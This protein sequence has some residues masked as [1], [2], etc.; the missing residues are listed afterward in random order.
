[1]LS[2]PLDVTS[3]PFSSLAVCGT[4][5]GHSQVCIHDP[6]FPRDLW[7]EEPRPLLWQTHSY[8]EKT[9]PRRVMLIHPWE[10]DGTAAPPPYSLPAFSLWRPLSLFIIAWWRTLLHLQPHK[11]KEWETGERKA[12]FLESEIASADFIQLKCVTGLAPRY[13]GIEKCI[14]SPS[15]WQP[16]VKWKFRQ[17]RKRMK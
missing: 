16:Q 10:K 3:V 8:D 11:E 2:W 15:M 13:K 9:T 12:S 6:Q 14:I 4:V 7:S 1:M 5:L 17:Y